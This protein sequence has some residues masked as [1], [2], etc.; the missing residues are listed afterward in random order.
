MQQNP[1]PAN[2]LADKHSYTVSPCGKL[3]EEKRFCPDSLS[4]DSCARCY[5]GTVNVSWSVSLD[6]PF[7]TNLVHTF[8]WHRG[9]DFNISRCHLY[10]RNL[11]AMQTTGFHTC[12]DSDPLVHLLALVL[13]GR[14]L[15]T[16]RSTAAAR[17]LLG[18]S[19][20]AILTLS[21]ETTPC[22]LTE[23]PYAHG[24]LT[25]TRKTGQCQATQDR[26]YTHP[27][28][29]NWKLA[30]NWRRR[31]CK[32]IWRRQICRRQNCL[33]HILNTYSLCMQ[34]DFS[35][36]KQKWVPSLH[37]PNWTSIVNHTTAILKLKSIHP[38]KYTILCGIKYLSHPMSLYD[39]DECYTS[40]A[41]EIVHSNKTDIAVYTLSCM[42]ER[43]LDQPSTA[44]L[45]LIL[46]SL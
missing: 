20:G 29:V 23:R 45:A 16:H 21:A 18:Y 15:L 34:T 13:R 19:R 33:G 42:L 8:L 24:T 31:E 27:C 4:A 39:M 25:L 22:I 26:I 40:A 44:Q 1:L 46:L 28:L 2:V 11:A 6:K 41:D 43:R 17:G 12:L 10:P 32:K 5:R 30:S 9:T 35:Q 7:W 37:G 14:I 38:L 3:P 36:L